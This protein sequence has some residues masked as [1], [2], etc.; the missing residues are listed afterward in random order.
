[1]ACGLPVLVNAGT[2]A[3]DYV[4][5]HGVGLAVDASDR[6]AVEDAMLQL[7][8]DRSSAEEMGRRGRA[9]VDEGLSWQAAAGRLVDAYGKLELSHS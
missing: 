2:W 6:A 8:D 7:K 9:V 4:I 1:M 5:E 3:G